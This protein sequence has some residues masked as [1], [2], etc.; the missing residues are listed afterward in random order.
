M[1]ELR[2]EPRDDGLPVSNILTKS[3][4]LKVD[5]VDGLVGS[6]EGTL[7]IGAIGGHC[8]HPPASRD[9][10]ISRGLGTSMEDND[11]WR[12]VADADHLAFFVAARVTLGCKDHSDRTPL[13]GG[14]FDRVKSVLSS[15]L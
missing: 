15:G 1:D 14:K 5:I 3:F 8:K 13:L 7:K 12:E 4:T 2:E 6:S 11:V 10:A 9:N